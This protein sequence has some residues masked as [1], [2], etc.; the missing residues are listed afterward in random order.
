MQIAKPILANKIY[1]KFVHQIIVNEKAL[2]KIPNKNNIHLR[3][4]LSQ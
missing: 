1:Q 2:I 3:L 4:Y